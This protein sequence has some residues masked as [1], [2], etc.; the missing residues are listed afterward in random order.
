MNLTALKLKKQDFELSAIKAIELAAAR[1]PGAVSLAQGIPSFNTPQIIKD[2]A[3]EQ[4]QNHKCDKYS[5]AT[6]ITELREEIS[7]SLEAEKLSYSPENEIL[8]TV[9]SIAGITASLLALTN[10]GD[11]VIIPSPSYTSYSSCILLAKCTPR[12]AAL[13]E[14]KNFDFSLEQIEKSINRKTRAILY[15]SP[16]NPTGTLFSEAKTRGLISLAI[17]HDLYLIADEVYKDFYYS[18]DPH[19]SA[20]NIPE[21]RDRLVR[22]CSFSKAFAMT[23]WRVGF[24]HTDQSLSERI[25]KYHDAMVTCAPV[26]SQYAALAALRFGEPYLKEFI[27]EFRKRRDYAIEKLDEMSPWL[28]Y[29][30]PKAAYFVF[31][32]IRDSVPLNH[33]SKALAYDILEKAKVALV[34]GEAFG[35]S[36]QSHLRIN[37]GRDQETLELGLK[38]LKEYFS[39]GKK[40]FAGT[41]FKSNNLDPL[42]AT[43]LKRIIA[44]I[45]LGKLAKF[46]IWR[47]GLEIIGIAGT[48]GKT[49]L[50]RTL[51]TELS[52]K[53]RVRSGLLSYNTEIGLSLSVLNTMPGRGLRGAIKTLLVALNASLFKS[54]TE[55]LLILEYGFSDSKEAEALLAI[56]KPE[57]LIVSD[58]V[59]VEPISS[60]NTFSDG[61]KSLIKSVPIS[62]IIWC[63]EGKL[64]A[65]LISLLVPNNAFDSSKSAATPLDPSLVGISA[66]RAYNAAKLLLRLR[67]SRSI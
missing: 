50:K 38:R 54:A 43:P 57:Y 31:P 10:P 46:Y 34:P 6:G 56:A 17:K 66:E 22:V 21:I 53:Y 18:N 58:L 44:Q 41:D 19:F 26:V 47:N 13:D 14:D 32:R 59:P 30:L 48:R 36:G 40:T 37:Y 55:Q 23:G 49:V 4:I 24:L 12:Y 3:C 42:Q 51:E 8:I 25:L 7:L 62:N 52:K 5:L 11:E 15:C 2:F 45:V 65:S 67:E 61:L 64:D 27:N 33:N 35:P 29:Q 28:D 16:N 20:A 60:Y 39:V 63:K 9:G 1:T